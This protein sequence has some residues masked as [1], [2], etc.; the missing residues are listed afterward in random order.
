MTSTGAGLGRPAGLRGPA[1]RT[2]VRHDRAAHQQLAAPDSPW[3]P[4]AER[5]RQAGDPGPAAPAQS[6]RLLHILRRFGEEQLR[7]LETW[8]IPPR[9]ERGSRAVDHNLIGYRSVAPLHRCPL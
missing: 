3:L 7:C 9:R 5:A 1:T 4:A 2:L 6:L 8:E